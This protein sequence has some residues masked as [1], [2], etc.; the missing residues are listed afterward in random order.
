M[1][2]KYLSH[3]YRHFIS[4]L[5][6]KEKRNINLPFNCSNFF[7]LGDKERRI[8]YKININVSTPIWVVIVV[9]ESAKINFKL[10]PQIIKKNHLLITCVF[11][12]I[13]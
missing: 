8:T 9:F 1:I 11:N 2:F 13:Y 7:C 6:L 10:F 5:S 12:S 3:S 4:S